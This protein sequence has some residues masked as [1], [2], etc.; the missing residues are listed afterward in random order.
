MEVLEENVRSIVLSGARS[1]LVAFLA[2]G[3]LNMPAMAAGEKPLGMVVTADHARLDNAKAAIGADVY[4]GDSVV[5]D[6]GGSLRLKVGAGQLYLLSQSSATFEPR[7]NKI[8]ARLDRGTMGFS[9]STSG[10]LQI[11][12]PMGLVRSADGQPIFGQVSVISAG[13]VRISSFEGT[14]LLERDGRETTI[15]QGEVYDATLAADPQSGSP[16]PSGAGSGGGGSGI[17]ASTVAK[18]AIPLAIAGLLACGLYPESDS[19]TG[20]F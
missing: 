14:L 1:C 3:L 8:Q 11:E 16:P 2:F 6:Q 5:T 15:A 17:S 18:I 10:Q 19:S 9:S 20:C 7:D 12:T 4:S 13:K